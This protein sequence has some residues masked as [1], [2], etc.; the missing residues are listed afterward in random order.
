MWHP[1]VSLTFIM[2]KANK[3]THTK[4]KTPVVVVVAKNGGPSNDWLFF[5]F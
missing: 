5:R 2:C 1:F 4:K 3:N